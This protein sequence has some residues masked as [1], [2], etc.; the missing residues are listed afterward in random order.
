MTLGE[1]PSAF[2]ALNAWAVELGL[3]R[4]GDDGA[5]LITI[6]YRPGA[7]RNRFGAH[8]KHRYLYGAEARD[9]VAAL[10]RDLSTPRR[11]FDFVPDPEA[12]LA[13]AWA[14]VARRRM[15]RIAGLGSPGLGFLTVVRL[16][17]AGGGWRPPL[18]TDSEHLETPTALKQADRP[19]AHAKRTA[20]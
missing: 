17:I 1:I 7:A 8:L 12:P 10:E 18:P 15:A 3:D 5:G 6:A 9:V 2:Q 4:P 16:E 20:R 11:Q 19:V 14:E 13:R